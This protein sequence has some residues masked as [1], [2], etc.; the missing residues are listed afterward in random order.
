M[1]GSVL[2]QAI[3][4][5]AC[6]RSGEV[7][8]AQQRDFEHW[9]RAA[10]A[11]AK[12]WAQV[13]AHLGATFSPMAHGL[14]PE[15]RSVLQ[16]PAPSRRHLLRGALVIGGLGVGT[17]LVGRSSGLLGELNAD[18]RTATA[19][20][21]RFTL[22][23]GSQLL[24]DARS[25]VNLEFDQGERRVELLA[26]KLIIDIQPQARSF[27]VITPYGTLRA[28]A[29]RFM[30]ARH[31]QSTHAWSLRSEACLDTQFQQCSVL[32]QGQ[33]LRLDLNGVSPLAANLR[34]ESLW[35][36]GRL[37]VDNWPLGAVIEA[38]RPYRHDRLQITAQAAQLR[39]SGLF[40]LD[41]SER[42]LN[43]L[44]QT[45]PIRV[46]R[47]IGLWTRIESA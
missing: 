25:A 40:A 31:T 35:E 28:A 14:N 16:G 34:G 32:R 1:T 17:L 6:M 20:R 41:N 45:L 26:G 8:A 3:E 44:E 37:S 15:L 4:W 13:Q 12:A 19:Q 27:N 38:L 11:H 39:V 29:G 42:V 9:L 18:L 47:F 46:R 5:T 22:A 24:L 7:D 23:D 2:E 10:P 33:G 30:L 43:S 36:D 21:Q